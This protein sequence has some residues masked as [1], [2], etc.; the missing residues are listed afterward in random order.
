MPRSI[1][2]ESLGTVHGRIRA[3]SA[4]A[5]MS[6]NLARDHAEL[7]IKMPGVEDA[8]PRASRSAGEL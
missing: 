8:R 4:T 5:G 3:M 1:K 2:T 6:C 7:A